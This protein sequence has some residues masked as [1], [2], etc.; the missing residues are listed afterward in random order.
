M[1][2]STLRYRL[3]DFF[4]QEKG[5]EPRTSHSSI[6]TPVT[7]LIRKHLT[8]SSLPVILAVAQLA[9]DYLPPRYSQLVRWSR[10]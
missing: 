7:Y 5:L 10:T 2:K 8:C 1:L 6:V 3:H 4:L 9:L